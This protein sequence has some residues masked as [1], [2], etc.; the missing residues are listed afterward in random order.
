MTQ[1]VLKAELAVGNHFNAFEPQ[2]G[3]ERLTIPQHYSPS[4]GL[5]SHARLDNALSLTKVVGA[6]QPKRCFH[7]AWLPTRSFSVR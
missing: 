1:R 3:I 7:S 5:N 4:M 6:S 2:D